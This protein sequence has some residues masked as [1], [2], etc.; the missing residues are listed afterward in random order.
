MSI[1]TDNII[2]QYPSTSRPLVEKA[3]KRLDNLGYDPIKAYDRVI[4]WAA[5]GKLGGEPPLGHS[6][7]TGTEAVIRA[8]GGLIQLPHG[9]MVRVQGKKFTRQSVSS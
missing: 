8:E 3:F 5:A 1:F 7:P 6:D 4:G 2:S 9:H